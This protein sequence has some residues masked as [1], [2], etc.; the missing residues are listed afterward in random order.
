[1]LLHAEVKPR[2]P[3]VNAPREA[4]WRM[5]SLA[6]STTFMTSSLIICGVFPRFIVVGLFVAYYA[7]RK[8]L[9]LGRAQTQHFPASRLSCPPRTVAL[10]SINDRNAVFFWHSMIYFAYVTDIFFSRR[11]DD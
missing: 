6:V 3:V 4:S 7:S 8:R 9:F 1:M 11:R 2:S 10:L 5:I